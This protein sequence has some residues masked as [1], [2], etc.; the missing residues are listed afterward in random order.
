MRFFILTIAWVCFLNY[1][2]SADA[3]AYRDPSPDKALVAFSEAPNGDVLENDF[4]LLVWNVFKSNEK[5]DWSKD[6]LNLVDRSDLVLLQ[7]AMLND[8]ASPV[9]KSVSDFGWWLAVGYIRNSDDA[10]AG[11]MTGARVNPVEVS[12]TRAQGQEPMSQTG[13]T[14]IAS[15]YKLKSGSELLVINTHGLNFVK[16][17]TWRK[18]MLQIEELL[19]SKQGP[20]IV[21]G[22]FNTW[23]HSRQRFLDQ[24]LLKYE[25]KRLHFHKDKRGLKLDHIYTRNCDSREQ[26]VLSD[27]LSSDHYPLIA[28]LYCD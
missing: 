1:P 17:S 7:E 25:I 8:F 16:N 12:Y 4:R 21:A 20:I 10:E 13:K 27:I 15:T 23:N 11:V 6:F 2:S 26:E 18:Q 3:K 24:L 22:D 5:E 19:K 28:K 14:T 9:Y